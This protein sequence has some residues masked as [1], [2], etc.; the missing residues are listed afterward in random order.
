[1][2]NVSTHFNFSSQFAYSLSLFLGYDEQ[3][4]CSLAG[5]LMLKAKERK[6]YKIM[7]F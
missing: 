2:Q 1:V 5:L 4:W 3:K 7:T 6:F